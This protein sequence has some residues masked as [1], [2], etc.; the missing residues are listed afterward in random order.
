MA[1][2]LWLTLTDTEQNDV[3]VNVDNIAFMQLMDNGTNIVFSN[4]DKLWVEETL[5]NNMWNLFNDN[6]LLCDTTTPP[7]LIEKQEATNE[8]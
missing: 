2:F 4:G 6:E 8:T 5:D 7:T 1:K 3:F